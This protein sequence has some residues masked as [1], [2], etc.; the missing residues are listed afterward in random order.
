[1]T[2]HVNISEAARL[3]GLSR[4][5]IRRHIN[6]GKLSAFRDEA[7]HQRIEKSELSEGC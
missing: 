3:M 6:S 7:G 5:T 2:Q 4:R 1:M